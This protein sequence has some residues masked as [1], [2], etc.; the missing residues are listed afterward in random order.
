MPDIDFKELGR[1][2]ISDSTTLVLSET[3]KEDRVIG[4]SVT[5]YIVSE[6]YTGFSKGIYIPEDS[7]IEF[8]KLF[9]KEDLQSAL[10]I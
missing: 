10:E 6:K 1:L 5:K 7:L 9:P 4:L 8:L 2:P 3:K